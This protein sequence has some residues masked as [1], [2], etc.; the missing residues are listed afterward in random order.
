ME[1][2]GA[3]P[4]SL[5]NLEDFVIGQRF[6]TGTYAVD[7]EKIKAF[8]RQFDPQPFHLDDDAARHTIFQGL[9]ASGW[10]TAAITMRLLAT[11][12]VKPSGG[13][14]GLGVEDLRWPTPVRPG[15]VLHVESE[16]LEVRPSMSRPD[17]GV[18]KIRHT[19]LNQEGACVQAMTPIL[20]VQR[21]RA[22]DP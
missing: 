19:T 3:R 22:E 16:V 13:I 7:A 6:R 18:V 4:A 20:L 17:H 1:E 9:V 12:D 15:D 8:A 5:Y 11:G 14:L 2:N 21:K 10:H